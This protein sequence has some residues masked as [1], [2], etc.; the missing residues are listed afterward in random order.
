M[1][2][3]AKDLEQLGHKLDYD[4]V[5]IIAKYNTAGYP[6]DAIMGRMIQKIILATLMA[7]DQYKDAMMA[8]DKK[9]GITP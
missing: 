9:R 8:L 6:L 4:L 7:L 3:T 5:T 1:K 2:L